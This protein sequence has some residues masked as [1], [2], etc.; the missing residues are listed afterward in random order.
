[1]NTAYPPETRFDADLVARYDGRGPRYTS[2]PTALQFTD[3][4]SADDYQKA[5]LRS[6]RSYRPLSLSVHSPVCRSLCYYCGCNKIVTRNAARVSRYLDYLYREIDMQ[7]EWFADTRRVTQLHFGG[8]TPTYLAAQQLAQLMARL[9]EAFT[10]AAPGEREFSIEVDPRTVD[11]ESIRWL[12]TL[13]F[14]RLSLGIQDFDPSVQKAVNRQQSEA[15]VQVLLDAARV[16]GFKSISFDLIYGLPLQT[17]SSFDRT[18]RSVIEMRPDRVA[19]YNYAHLP[20]R[21]KGQ[22]MIPA[23]QIPRPDTKLGILQRTIE[24]LCAAGYHYVG[25]DHFALPDDDLVKAQ[26]NGTLQRNFQGYATHKRCDLVGLGVSAISHVGDSFAQ[27][28]PATAVYEALLDAG[29]LPVQKG[30][31]IDA[32]DLIR[33]DLMQALMCYGALDVAE[34]NRRHGIKVADYFHAELVQLAALERDGLVQLS[35]ARIAV[36]PRGRLLL[37]SIVMCFDRHLTD[38]GNIERFSKAI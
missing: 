36:T 5:A 2:Y 21:F 30:L 4:F 12:A 28:A 37:R 14:N 3:H 22:R 11:E 23:Q 25:M 29:R 10:F 8:G 17:A 27:N 1:V 32:D 35:A 38:A 16:E 33:A 31:E 6:N 7:A 24:T 19:V 34:F 15:E 9:G 18:L 26:R 20:A 13:G